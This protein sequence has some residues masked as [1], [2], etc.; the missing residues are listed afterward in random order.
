MKIIDYGVIFGFLMV[1][2]I[3][4]WSIKREL[5]YNYVLTEGQINRSMDEIVRDSLEKTIDDI[6]LNDD[7]DYI[8]DFLNYRD[9]LIANIRNEMNFVLYGNTRQE[10]SVLMEKNIY[11]I[12]IVWGNIMCIYDKSGFK[13]ILLPEKEM[14]RKIK[15]IEEIENHVKS[16][17]DISLYDF[18]KANSI[19][20]YSVSV[21]YVNDSGY[22]G[23]E[24]YRLCTF[25]SAK[26][27]ENGL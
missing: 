12:Y 5:L 16:R 22:Y 26:V 6:Y 1:A 17:M 11:G 14:D 20:D 8:N 25:S 7:I 18:E 24:S 3:S 13:D 15:V 4:G 23:G 21:I 2:V 27:I 19:G 9:N 10:D